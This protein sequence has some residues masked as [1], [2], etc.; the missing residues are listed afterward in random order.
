VFPNHTR[1]APP[2]TVAARL[3]WWISLHDF[4]QLVSSTSP[5][6]EYSQDNCCRAE[7]VD[8]LFVQ[9]FHEF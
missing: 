1:T 8:L 3:G 4:M 2:K 9:A 5:Q 7:S 6:L